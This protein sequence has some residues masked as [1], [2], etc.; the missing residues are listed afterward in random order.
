VEGE[1]H[2]L[3]AMGTPGGETDRGRTTEGKA[4]TGKKH[5]AEAA[6]GRSFLEGGRIARC[7]AMG[8]PGGN[9]DRYPSSRG[10]GNVSRLFFVFR[11]RVIDINKNILF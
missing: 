9:D 3:Q 5:H 11:K 4:Q 1:N 6:E 2:A 8:T 7:K 10:Q